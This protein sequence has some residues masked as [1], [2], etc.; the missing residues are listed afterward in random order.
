MRV[1]RRPSICS[2]KNVDFFTFNVYLHHQRISRSTFCGCR[3]S[4]TTSRFVLGEFGMDTIRHAEEEAGG[5]AFV[6]RRQ[7][8]A[9]WSGGRGRLR[10]DR[11]VVHGR[12]GNHGWAFGLVTR[13]RKPKKSFEA[14]KAK[15]GRR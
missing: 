15:W 4:P 9:L 14:I 11:R 10:L 7:R 1:I 12:Y 2:R 3:I 13:E 5:H 8:R 6:A